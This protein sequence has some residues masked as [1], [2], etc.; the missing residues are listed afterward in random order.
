ML[1]LLKTTC[2]ETIVLNIHNP[3]KIH[4]FLDFIKELDFVE[5]VNPK[6]NFDKKTQNWKDDFMKI[7]TWN[8]DEN[9]IKL[10]DWKIEE[11]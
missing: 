3:E 10:K 1:T 8:L 5:I 7:G 4:L 2:M 11:F 9:E 6:I